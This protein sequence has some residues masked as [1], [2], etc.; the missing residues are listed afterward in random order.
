MVDSGKGEERR[1]GKSVDDFL[2]SFMFTC[3][4][5]FLLEKSA[6]SPL[7]VRH[8]RLCCAGAGHSLAVMTCQMIECLLRRLFGAM[9]H[10][11]AA[12]CLAT[13]FHAE[14]VT[15]KVVFQAT[16]HETDAH[17]REGDC[18]LRVPSL[19]MPASSMPGIVDVNELLVSSTSGGLIKISSS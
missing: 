16:R 8:S 10:C 4:S 13:T 15:T 3:P 12:R 1:T 14:S 6:P 11:R 9:R 7:E 5:S 19:R 2:V 17:Q 18:R